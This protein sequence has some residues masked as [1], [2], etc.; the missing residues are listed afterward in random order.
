MF[1]LLKFQMRF[2]QLIVVLEVFPR[3]LNVFVVRVSNEIQT[4][5]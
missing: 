4:F 3:F 5:V 2:R 1:S